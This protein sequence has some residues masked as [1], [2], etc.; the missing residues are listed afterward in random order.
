[1]A[2]SSCC[3]RLTTSTERWRLSA[4]VCPF[5]NFSTNAPD[6]RGVSPW[7][8]LKR[9]ST[10]SFEQERCRTGIREVDVETRRG[11]RLTLGGTRV[12][13]H[14]AR[15]TLRETRVTGHEAR[16]TARETRVTGCE[17]RPTTRETRVTER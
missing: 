17:A 1:M 9:R 11:T 4:A 6:R 10:A 7:M 2:R 5:S 16:L 13:G 15:P 3:P 8:R 14:E 12:T